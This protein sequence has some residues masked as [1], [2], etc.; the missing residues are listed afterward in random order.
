[1][2][3]AGGTLLQ[4]LIPCGITIAFFCQGQPYSGSVMLMWCGQNFFGISVYIRDARA[5]ALPLVGGEIHD[6]GYM[7]GKTGLL[8]YD[9]IIGRF[10]WSLG[11]ISVI[12]AFFLSVRFAISSS[13]I[14][15]AAE[16]P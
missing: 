13:R 14:H 12:A 5:K 3:M 8:E 2:S 9:Q 15:P 7:L 4:L 11:L 6:W 16:T 10:V 1:M